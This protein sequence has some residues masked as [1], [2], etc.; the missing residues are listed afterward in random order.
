[1]AY[2]KSNRT[3]EEIEGKFIMGWAEF[4]R[5]AEKVRRDGKGRVLRVESLPPK[6]VTKLLV[7]LE[8]GTAVAINGGHFE[9]LASNSIPIPF[10]AVFPEKFK[11]ATQ[12]ASKA[13]KKGAKVK[14]KRVTYEDNGWVDYMEIE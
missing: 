11:E 10:Q 5:S 12:I 14:I 2:K 1:M 4:K 9:P 13:Y 8:D 6:I 3:I 7:E